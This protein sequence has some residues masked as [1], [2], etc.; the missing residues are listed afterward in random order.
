MSGIIKKYFPDITPLQEKQFAALQGLYEQWNERINVISRKD[1]EHLYIRHVLHSLAIAK[2]C[3][4]D[5]GAKIL[6]V[7][8]GGGFPGIPLAILFPEAGF[9]MV[10][11][12]GKKIMVVGEVAEALSL[13][14]VIAVN[15]RVES[16][17]GKFHYVVSRAV[18]DMKSFEGWVWDKIEPGIHGTLPD[19]I[20]Y[21]K[22]GDLTA[23]LAEVGRKYRLY[24]ISDFFDEDFFETKKVVYIPKGH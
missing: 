12:V 6:D 4:F 16:I 18:T 21:L 17:D 7:G 24:D 20:L 8:C 10:D 2:V 19:G 5:D 11:S 3:K 1:I 9:T 14:N 13:R 22:G 23:E 15:S